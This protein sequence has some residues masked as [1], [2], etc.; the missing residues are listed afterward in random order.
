MKTYPNLPMFLAR[1]ISE[2]PPA[3]LAV[4]GAIFAPLSA[5]AI[6]ENCIVL[7]SA[8]VPPRPR[9]PFKRADEAVN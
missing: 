5:P 3:E 1:R 8:A 6:F 7:T 2:E 9:Y 4:R